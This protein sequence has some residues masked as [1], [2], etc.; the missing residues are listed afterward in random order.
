M[1]RKI[2]SFSI[3]RIKGISLIGDDDQLIKSYTA[4]RE[5]IHFSFAVLSFENIGS[6][7]SNTRILSDLISS[8]VTI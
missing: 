6:V 2:V 7:S 5:N 4:V 8:E 1:L 3:S